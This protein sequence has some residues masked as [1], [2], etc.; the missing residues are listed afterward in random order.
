MIR[1]P[2]HWVHKG[3]RNAMFDKERSVM[4]RNASSR[5]EHTAEGAQAQWLGMM[6]NLAEQIQK[7]QQ[8]SQQMT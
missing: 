2:L 6:H 3:F 4:D 5:M 1:E 8:T 7:Q